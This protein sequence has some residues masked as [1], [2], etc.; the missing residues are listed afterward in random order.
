MSLFASPIPWFWREAAAWGDAGQMNDTIHEPARDL[1]V[2]GD[3]D[4]CV[5]GG[6]CTGVFAAVRA[7]RLGLSVAIVERMGSLGGVATL[8]LVNVWHSPYD[9]VFQRRIFRGLTVELIDRL[10]ERGAVRERDRDP[11]W[12]WAFNSAEMQ[13]DL[14]E[15]VAEHGITSWL[16]VLFS[17]PLIEND[18]LVGVAVE[19]KSGREAIRARFFIDAS[20][21]GDLCTRAGAETYRASRHQPATACALFGGWEGLRDTD[22]QGLLRQHGSEFGLP[23]GFAWGAMVPDSEAYMLAATRVHEDCSTATG[24][25]RAEVEGRRQVRAIHDLLRKYAPAARLSL[26]ALPARI[27]IRETRHVRCLHR[28]TG[29]EV[30]YGRRFSDAIANGSYR[31]DIH[32]A[33]KPGITFRYLDGSEVYARPGYADVCSRWRSASDE[34]PT[35]YQIPYRSLVPVSPHGNL[36][37]AG[38]FIDADEQAH[39][40]IR[41][42]VNMNQTG[43]AAGAAAFLALRDNVPAAQVDLEKLRSTLAEGGSIM[44]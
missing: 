8:S 10:R 29:E 37:A 30:L 4:L 14:D 42:M 21:D 31:V 36:L 27:G 17:G 26:L 44:I 13:I 3:Y 35:F 1:P 19:T 11:S 22:W 12:A 25:A 34:N 2:I 33:D 20:G 40:A 6:S 39:A 18:R 43:E 23:E 28:L 38:R 41:V 16:H 7:A 5:I 9:E 15:L 24:F 32:H